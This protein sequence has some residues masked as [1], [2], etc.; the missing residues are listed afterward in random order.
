MT[1][2]QRGLPVRPQ[3]DGSDVRR[4]DAGDLERY[5]DVLAAA[6]EHDPLLE[7]VHPDAAGRRERLRREFEMWVRRVY[8]PLGECWTTDRFA[9][10]ATWAPP[11]WKMGP[12]AQLR[13]MPGTVRLAGRDS[14]RMVRMLNAFDRVHPKEPHWYLPFIGVAPEWQGRGF[15]SALLRP[16]LERCDAERVPAYLEST[17]PRNRALY[18]RHGFE[19]TGQIDIGR[20]APPVYAMWRDPA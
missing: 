6:F 10:A 13:L 18:E 5:A 15:G 12:L 14:G 17:S 4:I 9:G 16:V 1:V 19:V 3:P 20:G 11:G 8:R 2:D 7:W